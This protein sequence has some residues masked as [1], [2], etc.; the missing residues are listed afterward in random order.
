[1]KKTCQDQPNVPSRPNYSTANPS[2]VT[3]GNLGVQGCGAQTPLPPEIPQS[4]VHKAFRAHAPVNVR[5]PGVDLAKAKANV[6]WRAAGR[7]PKPNASDPQQGRRGSSD[8]NG[9]GKQ[10]PAF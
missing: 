7:G 1:M 10:N 6:L 5:R 2:A 4:Q 3:S 8:A 9:S